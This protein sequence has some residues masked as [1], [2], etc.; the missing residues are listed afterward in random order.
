MTP[1]SDVLLTACRT[2]GV[3]ST[4]A[5]LIRAAENTLYRLPGGV[6]A[7]ITRA[8]QFETARKEI[9]VSR[10]LQQEGIPVVEA[11][12]DLAQPIEVDGHAVTFW[13]E[14]PAHR[15]GSIQQVADVLHRIHALQ[16]PP[17]LQLP[18]LAPFVRLH[19]RIAE[20]TVFGHSDRE[21]L[22][23]HL[24]DLEQR[25]AELPAG[26][27][28]AAVHGDAW[29]GNIVDTT[30]GPVILDLERFA[31]GPPE[32][33]LTSIAVDHDTFATMTA[34]EWA[35]FCH[36]YGHDVTE[37]PGYPVLRAARELRKVTFAAQM[38]T[39]HPQLEDQALYRLACIKGE[40]GDRPWHWTPVP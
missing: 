26:L 24:T 17:E 11:L 30:S 40:R 1:A 16:P 29:G 5:E 20:A 37:W 4:G 22:L 6:V 10:W 12:P 23:E 25:Y 18:P 9:R 28:A 14:L 31:S 15:E 35:T 8:G 39:Q 33:D 19:Q 3:D 21:W 32:W 36:Q 38:A 13:R 34:Q 27:P 7:R 2:L